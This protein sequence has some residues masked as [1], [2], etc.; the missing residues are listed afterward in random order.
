MRSIPLAAF[1]S[2]P[3]LVRDTLTGVSAVDFGF[4][5][6][7]SV[8]QWRQ[9]SEIESKRERPRDLIADRLLELAGDGLPDSAKKNIEAL[10]SPETLAVVTGQQ[11]GLAGGP[12][13]SL[14]KAMNAVALAHKLEKESGIRTVPVF[15]MASSDHNLTE[16][17]Q[18]HWI[19]MRNQLAGYKPATQENKIPV[20]SL[21]LGEMATQL[22]QAIRTDMP[23]TEFSSEVLAALEDAYR[24]EATFGE[25]FLHL[26]YRLLGD[27]GLILFD[28]EDEATKVSAAPFW[29]QV[30]EHVDERLESIL[31]RSDALVHAGYRVQAPI[32]HGRP[33]LFLHEDGIRRKVVLSGKQIRARSDIVVERNE[34]LRIAEQEPQRFSAGVTLRPLLQGWLLPTAAYVGGSHEMAYWAQLSGAFEVESIP[35]P[36]LLPRTSLTLLEGKITKLLDKYEILPEQL[37]GSTDDI[38]ESI[39]TERRDEKVDEKVKRIDT[40]FRESESIYREFASSPEFAGLENAV[41][42]SFQKIQYHIDKLNDMFRDRA[43]RRHGDTIGHIE[44]LKTHIMPADQPQ[45]RVI[46]P[47]YFF[48]R[49][50]TGIVKGIEEIALNSPPSH[51]FVHVEELQR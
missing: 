12:L 2:T 26:S 29:Q 37:F 11:V 8:E 32:Q 21:K 35:R 38:I 46:S 3:D 18:I 20:G 6:E 25:A 34:L 30:I 24:P 50:G 44:K 10:R 48:V 23:D 4:S 17:A 36:A 1:P 16:A 49:Y 31:D 51:R 9:A 40:C 39:I 33:A 45:E 42:S 47:I 22:V 19:D 7:P 5:T 14:Y 13:L 43:R 27:T 41:R 28:P 15:W